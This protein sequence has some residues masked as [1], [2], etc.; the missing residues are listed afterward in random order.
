MNNIFTRE[1]LPPSVGQ[2]TDVQN[3]TP[4][5][6]MGSSILFRKSSTIRMCTDDKALCIDQNQ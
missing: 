3:C 4:F 1:N 2:L 5:D 6:A